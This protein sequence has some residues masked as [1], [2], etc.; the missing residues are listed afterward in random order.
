MAVGLVTAGCSAAAP[1]STPAP[2][3]PAA[4]AP[5][6]AVNA[7]TSEF[8]IQADAARVAAGEVTFTVTNKGGIEHEFVIVQTDLSPTALPK[9]AEGGVAEGGPLTKVD[10]LEHIAPGSFKVLTVKLQ[11]GKYAFFCNLPGHY[12]GGMTGGFE[13]VAVSATK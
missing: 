6:K 8:K 12:T 9:D 1:A 4:V 10:E 11:P 3:T 2:A 5:V 13:A 7:T